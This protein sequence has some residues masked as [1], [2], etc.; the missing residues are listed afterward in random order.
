[1]AAEITKSNSPTLSLDNDTVAKDNTAALNPAPAVGDKRAAI[2][3]PTVPA[4]NSTT[5]EKPAPVLKSVSLPASSMLKS[6]SLP[7]PSTSKSGSLPAPSVPK[8]KHASPSAP[9]APQPKTASLPTLSAPKSDSPPVHKNLPR[10]P[11]QLPIPTALGG[12]DHNNDGSPEDVFNDAWVTCKSASHVVE[13]VACLPSPIQ[14]S[15][16]AA[17]EEIPCIMLTKDAEDDSQC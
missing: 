10:Q 5:D 1:M 14:V 6:V 15:Q 13:N 4:T 8:P 9:S 3:A 17:D 16:A 12:D 2:S 11:E 7:M